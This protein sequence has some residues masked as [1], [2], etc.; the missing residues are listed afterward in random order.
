MYIC[1][2]VYQSGAQT[3][4]LHSRALKRRMALIQT[5]YPYAKDALASKRIHVRKQRQ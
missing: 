3:S 4:G 1:A 5:V 2:H